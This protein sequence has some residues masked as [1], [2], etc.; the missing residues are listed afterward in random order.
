MSFEKLGLMAEL[1]KAV[2]QKGYT[3][4]TPIQAQCIPLI[5]Q[6][7]DVMGGAQ[8]GTGKTAAFVLPIL[9]LLTENASTHARNG[10]QSWPR[11]LIITP[12]RESAAQIGE[13]VNAYGRGLDT[14]STVIFG[15]VGIDPQTARIMAGLEPITSGELK[16]G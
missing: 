13:S 12:T 14:T 16:V 1:V 11:A 5:L 15:E 7:G 2:A 4:T 6:G 10:K 3:K 9:Q 8:T